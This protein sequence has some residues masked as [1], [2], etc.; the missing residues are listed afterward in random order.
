MLLLRPIPLP[1]ARIFTPFREPII[2][3][4]PPVVAVA[5]AVIT[6]AAAVQ[7][8]PLAI[9]AE[10][11]SPERSVTPFLSRSSGAVEG[12]TGALQPLRAGVLGTPLRESR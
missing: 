12:D 10:T 3:V 2:A 7:V 6:V 11:E 4:P 9:V 8:F 1:L 5:A